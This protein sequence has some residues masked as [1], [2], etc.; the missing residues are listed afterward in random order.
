MPVAGEAVL[1]ADGGVPRKL[2]V[3]A[4]VVKQAFELV[5]PGGALLKEVR[6]GRG[7][8]FFS[9]LRASLTPQQSC[10]RDGSQEGL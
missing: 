1:T 6:G 8:A 4:T 3:S 5:E 10:S 2:M 9:R 7:R